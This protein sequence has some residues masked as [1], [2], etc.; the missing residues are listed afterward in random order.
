M[1]ELSR[2]IVLNPVRAGMVE[3]VENWSSYGVTARMKLY[4]AWFD[5]KWI[6]SSFG[7][8]EKIAIKHYIQFVANG[9]QQP[10]P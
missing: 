3:S 8:K 2:Y 9:V 1:Q 5:R 6:L 7:K 10:S 4:P